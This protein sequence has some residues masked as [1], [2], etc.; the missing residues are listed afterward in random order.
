MLDHAEEYCVFLYIYPLEVEPEAVVNRL[1]NEYPKMQD[2]EIIYDDRY[3]FIPYDENY[4]AFTSE[5]KQTIWTLT[6]A[7][8][9]VLTFDITKCGKYEY[10]DKISETDKT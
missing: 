10:N 1:K 3:I 8:I 2:A 4:G 7:E 6:A 9:G 5:I